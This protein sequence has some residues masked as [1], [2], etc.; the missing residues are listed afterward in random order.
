[1]KVQ[2]ILLQT[3]YE[4]QVFL[5]DEHVTYCIQEEAGRQGSRSSGWLTA[6]RHAAE[7]SPGPVD[8]EP[9]W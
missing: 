3:L 7:G 6:A 8:P 4:S 1:M 5:K 2:P 9:T